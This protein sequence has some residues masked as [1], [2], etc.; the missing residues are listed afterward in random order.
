V[1][2]GHGFGL[3]PSTMAEAALAAL[4]EAVIEGCEAVGPLKM[5]GDVV[6]VPV[7]LD[8]GTLR[9]PESPGLGVTIDAQA[10]AR[11]RVER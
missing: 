5:A 8:R 9:L 4:S 1:V 7:S 6:A 11:H 10:L 2:V 3:T